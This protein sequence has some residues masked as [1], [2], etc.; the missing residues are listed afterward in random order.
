MGA[1][2][3]V[4]NYITADRKERFIAYAKSE[5]FEIIEERR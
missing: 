3:Y 5:G 1:P 4:L 2:G